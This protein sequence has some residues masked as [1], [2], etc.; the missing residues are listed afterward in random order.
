MEKS[1]YKEG[2]KVK[3]IDIPEED[4]SPISIWTKN[5]IYRV[6][7]EQE[8]NKHW[9]EECYENI[10]EG[11]TPLYCENESKPFIIQNDCIEAFKINNWKD[12]IGDTNGL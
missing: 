10:D 11:Y 7:G 4:G 9:E 6:V 1:K 8:W 5:K 2:E 3:V 12:K